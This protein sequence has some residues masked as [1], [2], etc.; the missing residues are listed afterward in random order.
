MRGASTK[1]PTGCSQSRSLQGHRRA[2][3]SDYALFVCG[4]GSPAWA[5]WDSGTGQWTTKWNWVTFG[6][7]KKSGTRNG[8]CGGPG[9]VTCRWL[10]Q[11]SQAPGAFEQAQKVTVTNAIYAFIDG[12]GCGYP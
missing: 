11:W 5:I 1:A 6:G 9:V 7:K 10:T 4:F 8:T 3:A 12:S 2:L